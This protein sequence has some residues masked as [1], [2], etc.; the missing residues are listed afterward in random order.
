MTGDEKRK[1]ISMQVGQAVST[2]EIILVLL[3]L[4]SD[5]MGI[6]NNEIVEA[7]QIYGLEKMKLSELVNLDEE[8]GYHA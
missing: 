8:R 5:R 3:G 1:M 4:I 6:T 7:V 2:D